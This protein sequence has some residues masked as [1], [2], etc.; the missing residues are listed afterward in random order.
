MA[1][2][3]GGHKSDHGFLVLEIRFLILV[4]TSD[5]SGSQWD[6]NT[7]KEKQFINLITNV[8]NV[9]N[10]RY[11]CKKLDL[12]L[13]ILTDLLPVWWFLFKKAH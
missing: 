6:M 7:S 10:R 12:T 9:W 11:F 4:V 3:S 2:E 8:Q 13:E 5:D 1:C